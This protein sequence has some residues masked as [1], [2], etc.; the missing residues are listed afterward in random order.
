[1]GKVIIYGDEARAKLSNGV[2]TI[3]KAVKGTLGPSGRNV[4]IRVSGGEKK[5]FT[6]KDGVTVAS[7]IESRCYVE[8]QAIELIQDVANLADSKAGDGTTTATILAEAIFMAGIQK[9]SS[10]TNLLDLKRGIDF[11][12]ATIVERLKELSVLCVTDKGEVDYKKLKE[13]ALISSNDDEEISEVVVDAFKTSGKQ[14]VVNIKRSRNHET[15]LTTI[16]GMNL[17]TGYMSPYYV[18]DFANDTANHTAPYVYMTNENITTLTDNFQALIA[19]VAKQQVPLLIIC[20]DMDIQVSTTLITNIT[21]GHLKVC[22]C[23]A[24]GF[25]NEQAEELKDLGV[26][27]GKNPF[28]ENSGMCFNDLD[29][30]IKFDENGDYESSEVLSHLPQSEEIILSKNSL[31][32]KGPINIDEETEKKIN[33]Q[34]ED[35]V[36]NLRNSLDKHVTTFEQ[37]QIQTRISRLADGIAYINIGA[38]SDIEYD[39]KQARIQDALYAVKSAYE[40]GYLP[41]GGTALLHVSDMLIKVSHK[42]SE[43]FQLGIDIVL[44]AIKVPFLQILKNV[45]MEISEEMFQ[46]IMTNFNSGIDARTRKSSKNMMGSGIIDPTKVTRVALENAAS[47][48]GSLL[49]TECIIIDTDAYAKADEFDNPF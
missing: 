1:M 35:R 42:H 24:P 45:G 12:T 36:E 27:L 6:T 43:S 11:G 20:K 7:Q 16:S 8:Q 9:S 21:A 30:K 5:P 3:S 13:I 39:E 14:G 28:L 32:I 25:G 49:T 48:A 29:F 22:V 37:G 31:S 10:K 2:A 26:V 19:E 33:E 34:T 46:K 23:K 47:I 17:S 44:D 38:I 41:G 18:N 15:Y 4:L 40:E